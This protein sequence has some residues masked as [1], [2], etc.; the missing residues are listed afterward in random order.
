MNRTERLLARPRPVNGLSTLADQ[1]SALMGDADDA[2]FLLRWE[3][4]GRVF[5]RIHARRSADGM[6]YTWVDEDD[7]TVVRR[8]PMPVSVMEDLIKR[9]LIEPGGE[10]ILVYRDD[11][12]EPAR[13]LYAMLAVDDVLLCVWQNP[14]P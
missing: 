4:D 13:C 10:T 9:Q 12:E 3:V 2:L 6:T 1:L 8:D 11:D 14:A 7:A 5:V